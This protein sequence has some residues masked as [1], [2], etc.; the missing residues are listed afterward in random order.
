MSTSKR[1]GRLAQAILKGTRSPDVSMRR[2]QTQKR[3]A[4][5]ENEPEPL[6]RSGNGVNDCR[7]CRG[8]GKVPGNTEILT[9]FSYRITSRLTCA[10]CSGTGMI[11]KPSAAAAA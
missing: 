10:K 9:P 7:R 2:R 4:R 11:G 5:I 1:F 6:V 3:S 8:T